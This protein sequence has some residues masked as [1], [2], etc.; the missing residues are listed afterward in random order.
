[1]NQISKRYQNIDQLS[2][3]PSDLIRGPIAELWENCNHNISALE[4]LALCSEIP[5]KNTLKNTALNAIRQQF[6]VQKHDIEPT[7]SLLAI[8]STHCKWSL[9]FRIDVIDNART[10]DFPNKK[11]YR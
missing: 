7:L 11:K 1:M 9:M 10:F 8:D 3:I 2:W 5:I 4:H 6:H